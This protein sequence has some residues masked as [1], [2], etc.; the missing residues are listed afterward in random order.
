MNPVGPCG[1]LTVLAEPVNPVGPCGPLT[2]LALPVKPVGPCGPD[3]I[4]VTNTHAVPFHSRVWVPT[5]YW[6]PI[7]GLLGKSTGIY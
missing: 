2:V 6:S 3:T 1:P 7:E 5:V 4:V